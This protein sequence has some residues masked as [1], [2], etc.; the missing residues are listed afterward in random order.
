MSYCKRS[1][2]N[3]S[4]KRKRPYWCF[5]HKDASFIVI[6]SCCG[7]G[8]AADTE[9]TTNFISANIELHKLSTGRTVGHCS[10][11]QAS[12]ISHYPLTATSGHCTED[13]QAIPVQVCLISA[14]STS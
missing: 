1:K 14:I 13:A 10:I 3:N 7:A 12:L 11:S 6:F 8:T 9:F 2:I 4:Y 5:K